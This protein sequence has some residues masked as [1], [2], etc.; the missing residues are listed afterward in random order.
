MSYDDAIKAL[1]KDALK[2]IKNNQTI[3]LGSGRAATVLVKSLSSHVN[4][5]K[6]NI[7]CIPTSAQIK[8]VAEKGKLHLIEADQINKIDIVSALVI[9]SDLSV[10]IQCL[11]M[12]V[13]SSLSSFII[14][15]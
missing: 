2:L 7:K 5:K 9:N 8:M 14:F 4:K 10:V 12:I 13:S 6:I 1:S 3:G 15:S 11:N